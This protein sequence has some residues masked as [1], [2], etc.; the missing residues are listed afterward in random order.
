MET[1]IKTYQ[2]VAQAIKDCS[3]EKIS[4]TELQ[5]IVDNF[6]EQDPE[7]NQKALVR[8]VKNLKTISLPLFNKLNNEQSTDNVPAPGGNQGNTKPR[9][10]KRSIA[11][12][13]VLE[14]LAKGEVSLDDVT[15]SFTIG[16]ALL[17][18][19]TNTFK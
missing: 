11:Y 3:A 5:E 17:E 8:L 2:D 1:I 6:I 19:L 7:N 4:S 12:P 14:N 10:T 13:T 15:N 16:K 9:L 18:E